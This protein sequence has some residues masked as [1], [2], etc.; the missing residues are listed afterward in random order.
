MRNPDILNQGGTG[1]TCVTLGVV[2]ENGQQI[3]YDKIDQYCFM[4]TFS[5]EVVNQC[6]I[7]IHNRQL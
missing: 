4:C 6:Q 2:R 1:F 3:A 5:V 7:L